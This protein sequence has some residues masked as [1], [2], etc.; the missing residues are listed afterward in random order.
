[1]KSVFVTVG[2]T[3]FPELVSA[4]LAEGFTDL[5]LTLG[6]E[7]LVVQGGSDVAADSYSCNRSLTATGSDRRIQDLHIQLFSYKESIADDVADAD[8]VITHAGA[9]SILQTLR[10]QKKCL[11]VVNSALMGNHQLELA[12]HLGDCGYIIMLN[13]ITELSEKFRELHDT[14][15]AVLRQL[16]PAQPSVFWET[17]IEPGLLLKM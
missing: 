3:R 16:P 6:Y 1:M 2:T 7:S 17:L 9:G 13:E 11:A 15:R 8:V 4:V 12:E 14:E 10:A 5:L